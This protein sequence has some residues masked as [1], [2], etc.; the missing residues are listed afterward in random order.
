MEQLTPQDR[1]D[2][3]RA[4]RDRI[5]Q[6]RA[7]AVAPLRDV[8][9]DL[10]ALEGLFGQIEQMLHEF[11]W[12]GAQVR[13]E[14]VVHAD[15]TIPTEWFVEIETAEGDVHICKAVYTSYQRDPSELPPLLTIKDQH[16]AHSGHLTLR[17]DRLRPATLT[18][19]R[20]FRG[21]RVRPKAEYRLVA[22]R[23]EQPRYRRKFQVEMQKLL[24]PPPPSTSDELQPQIVDTY[25]RAIDEAIEDFT[26]DWTL[27]R[28]FSD[29]WAQATMISVEQIRTLTDQLADDMVPQ[30]ALEHLQE[31]PKIEHSYGGSDLRALAAL[32]EATEDD[33][34]R[35]RLDALQDLHHALYAWRA[36][37][38]RDFQTRFADTI[39]NTAAFQQA[40]SPAEKSSW[41]LAIVH[42]VEDA[43]RANIASPAEYCDAVIRRAAEPR[44]TIAELANERYA[45]ANENGS[46]H[47]REGDLTHVAGIVQRQGS[48]VVLELAA[49]GQIELLRE[50]MLLLT[51]TYHPAIVND[52]IR[53]LS[54]DDL[55]IVVTAVNERSVS[56]LLVFDA[57]SKPNGMQ[58]LHSAINGEQDP[59]PGF[60]SDQKVGA[61]HPYVDD[62]ERTAST[63]KHAQ[64]ARDDR[65]RDIADYHHHQQQQQLLNTAS[66]T[67]FFLD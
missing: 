45:A 28:I 32:Y 62:E 20:A 48:P 1:A 12:P 66:D 39:A 30:A 16:T 21:M 63:R 42:S 14:R 46:L 41:D 2:A 52:N 23:W 19:Q 4:E 35:E 6:G 43:D 58:L 36:S 60:V 47:N 9:Q 51:A 53:R 44:K 26:Q 67:T 33:A 59:R 54:D 57:L 11:D 5:G 37:K 40:L 61:H 31:L 15:G 56:L 24:G 18:V 65:R 8:E 49:N 22:A 17:G 50:A 38:A 7:A 64:Q 13:F 3:I 55:R 10:R 27:K 29:T 25:R 34:V